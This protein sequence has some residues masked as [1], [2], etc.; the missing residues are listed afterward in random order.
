MDVMLK[1]CKVLISHPFR[2]THE[3]ASRASVDTLAI[4]TPRWGRKN[5]CWG[6]SPNPA[7]RDKVGL[8]TKP[9]YYWK[10]DIWLSP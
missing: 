5:A 7:L 10:Y 6:A 1:K 9:A 2:A 8:L 3:T 4:F